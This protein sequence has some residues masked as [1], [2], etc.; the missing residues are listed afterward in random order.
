M[1]R[2]LR[3]PYIAEPIDNLPS[4]ITQGLPRVALEVGAELPELSQIAD[5]VDIEPTFRMRAGGSLIEARVSLRAAYGDV[6]IDVRADGMTPPVIVKP[7]VPAKGK[8]AHR[9]ASPQARD[10]IPCD[11]A[12]Q[13]EA[14]TSLRALGLKP[15][16][17]GNGLRRA[18]RRRD[19]V[20][21]RGARRAARGLGSLH[22]GRPRRRAGAQQPLQRER[23]RVERRR[24]A[25]ARA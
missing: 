9:A 25:D 10:V 21:D 20:L 17:D 2:L 11:I 3:T 22:P 14:T 7:P 23:A 19:P 5:V 1:R 18:R 4:L 8:T 24:L 16:E 6:E 15:D 13:Q 12:A